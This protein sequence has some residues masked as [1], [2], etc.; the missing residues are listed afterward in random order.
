[1]APMETLYVIQ[2]YAHLTSVTRYAT[3][4]GVKLAYAKPSETEKLIVTLGGLYCGLT[5]IPLILRYSLQPRQ[6]PMVWVSGCSPSLVIITPRGLHPCECKRLIVT[7]E[8][9]ATRMYAALLSNRCGYIVETARINAHDAIRLAE[10]GICSLLIGDEGV[11]AKLIARGSKTSIYE[12]AEIA[13]KLL[14]I[15]GLVFAATAGPGCTRLKDALTRLSRV[16][17]GLMDILTVARMLRIPVPLAERYL[18]CT[19]LTFNPALLAKSLQLLSNALEAD[20]GTRPKLA[21]SLATDT[22]L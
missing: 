3:R 1:M 20:A 15:D 9:V 2:P 5:P 11:R 21:N 17:A 12:F 7:R 19:R 13:S 14:S 6:G 8:S 16:E 10:R 4:L 18:R 22:L